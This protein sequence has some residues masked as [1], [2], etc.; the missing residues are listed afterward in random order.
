MV[1]QLYG[2]STWCTAGTF[3][4]GAFTKKAN[5]FGAYVAFVA[6]AILVVFLK[7]RVPDVTSWAYSLI[8]ISVSLVVGYIAS[9]I[10]THMNGTISNPQSHTT[11]Y[12]N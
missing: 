6:S 12:N 8:S 10:Y 1:Q 11:I 9:I 5:A 4:F 3:V 2:L 7:Y